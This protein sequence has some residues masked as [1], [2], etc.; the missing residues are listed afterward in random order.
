[1]ERQKQLDIEKNWGISEQSEDPE[2]AVASNTG[3]KKDK[4]TGRRG[5]RHWQPLDDLDEK[6]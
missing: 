6:R 1:V 3:R 4:V 5:R 2:E